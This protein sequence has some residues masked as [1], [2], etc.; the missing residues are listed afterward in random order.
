MG[1]RRIHV[2]KEG[3]VRES[4]S[5]GKLI[6]LFDELAGEVS[7]HALIHGRG[8]QEAIRNNNLALLE[9]RNNDLANELSSAGGKEQQFGLR[10]HCVPLGRVLQ[11][12]PDALADWRSARFADH[13]RP[14]AFGREPFAKQVDL[15]ALA[16]S[17]S[18]L[19]ADEETCLTEVGHRGDHES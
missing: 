1:G 13:D 7:R 5:R 11:Q 19:E 16:A 17:L 10:D 8:V 2:E 18:P 3:H 12:V 4:W 9:G 14:F 15:G 6:D